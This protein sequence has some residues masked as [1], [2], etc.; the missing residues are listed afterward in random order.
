MSAAARLSS[1]LALLASA[2]ALP[3]AVVPESESS[4]LVIAYILAPF[5][6]LAAVKLLY[7]RLRKSQT[8][9]AQDHHQTAEQKP[10]QLS[11][12]HKANLSLTLILAGYLVG[13]LGSPHW[14]TR[15]KC[16][17]D[18]VK[19]K[20]KHLSGSSNHSSTSR[21]GDAVDSSSTT[22]QGT[23]FHT[24]RT[25]AYHSSPQHSRADSRSV[26]WLDMRSPVLS[27][28]LGGDITSCASIHPSSPACSRYPAMPPLPPVAHISAP[29]VCLSGGSPSPTLMQIMEPVLSSWYDEDDESNQNSSQDKPGNTG[30]SASQTR[31][32]NESH[33]T[34]QS[35]KPSS[36]QA[37]A[38]NATA[39][40]FETPPTSPNSDY[41]L[42]DVPILMP[43]HF[44]SSVASLKDISRDSLIVSIFEAPLVPVPIPIYSVPPR[45]RACDLVLDNWHVDP[46]LKTSSSLKALAHPG[47]SRSPK[48]FDSIFDVLAAERTPL[49]QTTRPLNVP[50]RAST[51]PASSSSLPT[52]PSYASEV[53]ARALQS[54]T[55]AALAQRRQSASPPLGPSPLRQSVLLD[56]PASASLLSLSGSSI[57]LCVRTSISLSSHSRGSWELDDLVR[58]G[59][60]DVD[61]VSAVLG[62]GLSRESSRRSSRAEVYDEDEG[63]VSGEADSSGDSSDSSGMGWGRAR[64][65]GT[66][67]LMLRTP[68]APLCAIPEETDDIT[69]LWGRDPEMLSQEAGLR[70]LE[71]F[72]EDAEMREQSV[73]EVSIWEEEGSWRDSVSYRDSIGLAS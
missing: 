1:L 2:H 51:S 29:G 59:Q 19:R 34:A 71:R 68:G 13:F 23:S 50:F 45:A 9:H 55:K 66:T 24:T 7:L 48:T 61:A 35:R 30:P 56:V 67:T 25:S 38:T 54:P 31:S 4:P 46:G 52:I 63:Q 33:S 5:P 18:K 62:L 3:L 65:S 69:E 6:I 22:G 21:I 32:A 20:S 12:Q 49:T 44:S 39:S 26:S 17:A 28:A 40:S 42:S 57:S 70:G 8:I 58:D 36:S 11:S 53:V 27:P 43:G 73:G 16:R 72:A 64:E 15:I 37:G 47:P 10:A 60:L 41:A 14:E